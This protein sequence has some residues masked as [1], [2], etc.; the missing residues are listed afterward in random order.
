[1]DA[2]TSRQRTSLPKDQWNKIAEQTRQTYLEDFLEVLSPTGLGSPT[3]F[4]KDAKIAALVEAA[5]EGNIG[6]LD[7]LAAAGADVNTRGKYGVT[8]LLWA[9]W[10]RNKDGFRRLLEHRA[11]PDCET[12]DTPSDNEALNMNRETQSAI[13]FAAGLPDDSE[14]L[15]MLLKHHANVNHPRRATGNVAD[16]SA[17]ETPI[18]DAVAATNIENLDMLIRAGA[19]LNHQNRLGNTPMIHAVQYGGGSFQIVYRLLEAGADYRIRNKGGQDIAFVSLCWGGDPNSEQGQCRKKVLALLE[20]KGADLKTARETLAQ[21]PTP[22]RRD[23]ADDDEGHMESWPT[24]PRPWPEDKASEPGIQ[25]ETPPVPSQSLQESAKTLFA[26]ATAVAQQI[27]DDPHTKDVVLEQ[28]A[29]AQGAATP[30]RRNSAGRG[31]LDQNRIVNIVSADI[32]AG[33]FAD[34]LAMADSIKEKDQQLRVLRGVAVAQANAG[35]RAQARNT[36]AHMTTIAGT[37]ADKTRLPSATCDIAIVQHSVGLEKE[38]A[39]T[40][41]NLMAMLPTTGEKRDDAI[42]WIPVELADA[43]IF[44]E[45]VAAAGRIANPFDRAMRLKSI[46]VTQAKA[47]QR[48]HARETFRKATAA[49]LKM[50]DAPSDRDYKIHELCEIARAEAKAGFADPAR[51]TCMAAKSADGGTGVFLCQVATTQAYAGYFAAALAT[52]RNIREAED[53]ADALL[54]IAVRLS[55]RIAPDQARLIFAEAIAVARRLTNDKQQRLRDKRL[56]RIIKEMAGV[57]LF[58]EARVAVC[59]INVKMFATQAIYEI[60]IAQADA[61]LTDQSRR[62]F[63]DAAAAAQH[64]KVEDFFSLSDIAQQ[65]AAAG[66]HNDARATV[67]LIHNPFYKFSALGQ[68]VAEPPPAMLSAGGRRKYFRDLLAEIQRIPCKE[69]D[70]QE[71]EERDASCRELASQGRPLRRCPCHRP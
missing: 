62:T 61:G 26:E 10:A 52:T 4:F 55:N 40:L 32:K 7:R 45:A 23:D 15:E 3:R 60:A 34:A 43:G 68:I 39:K 2:R 18:F 56:C 12:D 25:K 54:G 13:E 31:P 57:G 22:R 49:A 6:E 24:S 42:G 44:P 63:N 11:D 27:K 37:I 64:E 21:R 46:A 69:E 70:M 9:L 48:E 35:L 67:A 50:G 66:F 59:N 19:D 33:R 14:W 53:K 65:Q 71:K 41:A 16:V 47:G 28:I 17:G 58:D 38:A 51:Q 29:T 30:S 1:M 36:L 8:P 5:E 20:K